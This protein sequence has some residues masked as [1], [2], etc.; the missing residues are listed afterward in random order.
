[1]TPTSAVNI[2]ENDRKYPGIL[3]PENVSNLFDACYW[4]PYSLDSPKVREAIQRGAVSPAVGN[5]EDFP[6]EVA[7]IT[8]EYDTLTI[9]TERMRRRLLGEGTPVIG[10]SVSG[11]M[12]EGVGHGWDQ[13][14]R[15]GQRGFKEKLEAYDLAAQVIRRSTPH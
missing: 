4:F 5:V 9:E 11:W 1:M 7:L 10:T 12:V 15:H 8:A 14:T 2:P 3:I 13:Q 6:T